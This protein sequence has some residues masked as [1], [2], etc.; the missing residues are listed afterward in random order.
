MKTRYF[1][2][3]LTDRLIQ[4]M[5]ITRTRRVPNWMHSIFLHLS[6]SYYYIL[7]KLEV[8]VKSSLSS[9]QIQKNRWTHIF[10]NS[11]NKIDFNVWNTMFFFCIYLF[12]IITYRIDEYWFF[13]SVHCH[14]FV[15]CI[16]YIYFSRISSTSSPTNVYL[17]TCVV[18]LC[19]N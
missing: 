4:Q 16:D 2:P 15:S 19:W 9:T 6:L 5:K 1:T 8:Q 13:L 14:F 18:L 10:D 17:K 7:K 3:H 12:R 11:Y